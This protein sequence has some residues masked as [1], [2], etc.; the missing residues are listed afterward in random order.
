MR[1]RKNKHMGSEMEGIDVELIAAVSDA[2]AHPVRIELF[3]YIMQ[4]NRSME[5]VCTKDLVNTFD[6]AQATI[7][8]HMKKLLQSGLVESKKED[9]F[10]YYYANLG[11]LMRYI[12]ATKK[13]SVL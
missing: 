7:S 12:D 10:S 2:L 6:Y 13:F 1:I 8:Q 5:K 9:R 11:V 3:R 4:C